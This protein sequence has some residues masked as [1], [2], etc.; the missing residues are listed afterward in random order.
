MNALP[1]SLK[2]L[3]IISRVVSASISNQ[4]CT[5][6]K[7]PAELEQSGFLTGPLQFALRCVRIL[8]KG[9]E[10]DHIWLFNAW[11]NMSDVFHGYVFV[12]VF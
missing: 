7:F 4:D 8:V 6:F 1:A 3:S 12:I 9:V 5:G 10:V 11:L 2:R